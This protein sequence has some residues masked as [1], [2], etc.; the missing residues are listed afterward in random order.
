MQQ[1]DRS[2]VRKMEEKVNAY[3]KQ[4]ENYCI[5]GVRAAEARLWSDEAYGFVEQP[6]LAIIYK[7]EMEACTNYITA[8]DIADM[9][10]DVQE[11]LAQ[12]EI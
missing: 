11:F 1:L 9:R 7:P 10:F 3:L 6:A 2:I 12:A 8:D 4:N 5:E